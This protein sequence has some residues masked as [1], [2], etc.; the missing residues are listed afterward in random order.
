MPNTDSS[1]IG[2]HTFHDAGMTCSHSERAVS[3]E[4][5]RV[6]GVASVRVD[7]DTGEVTV[8]ATAPVRRDQIADAVDEAGYS[9][10]S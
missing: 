6:A 8:T 10:A 1:F 2:T 3:E 7:L 4:I 5:G 9:L